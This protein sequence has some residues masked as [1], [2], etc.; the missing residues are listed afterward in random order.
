MSV[1]AAFAFGTLNIIGDNQNNTIAVSRN[2]AGQLLVNG[3]AISIFGGTPTVINTGLISVLGFGGN[4]TIT[5]DEING[6]L[7][8]AFL[9]GGVGND[10][11]TGGSRN[12]RLVGQ[13]GNDTLSGMGGNDVLLGGDN[14]DIL[15]GGD[16]NDQSFGDAGND[17]LVW[18]LGDD[19]DLNEGG[20]G[21]DTVEVNGG[22]DAETFAVTANDTRVRFDRLDTAPFSLDIGTID[23]SP[24]LKG[25]RFI[26]P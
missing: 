15:I 20:N 2:A 4:D 17:R 25:R 26:R 5:L 13:V 9:F 23:I 24:A 22:N 16:G 1:V 19:T 11:I 12:D 14:D 3:G 8:R 18:N 6:L 21:T 10:V 7:P